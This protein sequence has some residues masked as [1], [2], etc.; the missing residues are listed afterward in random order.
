MQ[1]LIVLNDFF[2]LLKNK[3][4]SVLRHVGIAAICAHTRASIKPHAIIGDWFRLKTYINVE[5]SAAA[6]RF[7]DVAKLHL[8][9]D[10]A[11]SCHQ[12]GVTS[13]V[14]KLHESLLQTRRAQWVWHLAAHHPILKHISQ[15]SS[16]TLKYLATCSIHVICFRQY[17]YCQIFYTSM[18]VQKRN[19]PWWCLHLL[20]IAKRLLAW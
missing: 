7:D 16:F 3:H 13:L 10:L 8:G 9:Y 5:T 12:L 17:M 11:S 6:A 2:C 4:L 14:V 18:Y 1:F 15:F 20:P 19:I